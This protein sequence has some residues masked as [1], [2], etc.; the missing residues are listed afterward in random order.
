MILLQHKKINAKPKKLQAQF[1]TRFL[2][3]LLMK[4][5]CCNQEVAYCFVYR[6]H[7]T[8]KFQY[9]DITLIN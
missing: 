5:P 3:L 7:F 2:I 9:M 8:L 1:I 6:F 4:H